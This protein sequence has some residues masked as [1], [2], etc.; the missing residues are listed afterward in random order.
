MQL[1]STNSLALCVVFI[2]LIACATGQAVHGYLHILHSSTRSRTTATVYESA[3][4]L[5]LMLMASFALGYAGETPGT[6]I[7]FLY[8]GSPLQPALWVNVAVAIVA[9][10][11]ALAGFEDEDLPANMDVSWIPAADALIAL[12]CIPP[13][14]NVLGDSWPLV[15]YIDAAYF[16]FRTVYALFADKQMRHKLV[17]PLSI[18]E[19]MKLLP[20]GLLYA[21]KHGRTLVANDAM[22][23]CLSALGLSTDFGRVDDL[24]ALLNERAAGDHAV[25][26]AETVEWERGNWVLLRIGPHEVRLFS[27]EGLGFEQ[28]LNYP[29]AK[30]LDEESAIQGESRRLLGAEAR[31]RVIAYDMTSEVEIMQEIDRT[32]AELADSQRELQE[33][34]LT[35]QEA[36]ENEAMLRMRGRVHDVIGQRLSMLHRALEDKDLSD[37]KLDQLKPLLNGILDDL[38]DGVRVEPADELSATVA[39]FALTGVD[40]RIDGAL[41]DDEQTAKLFV[42]CIR[43]GTTNAVK[44]AHATLVNVK[45]S[46]NSLSITND[47]ATPDSDIVEGTG[48]ANMRRAVEAAGGTLSISPSPFTLDIAIRPA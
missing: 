30:S 10:Y 33:S 2:A 9:G 19:A 15:L 17:S 8:L 31:M 18:A 22:R 40:V 37:E 29:S 3:L 24:W 42:D 32:N 44:H 48:L 26:V 4:L 25:P 36:A 41:P 14:A 16:L 34:M 45:C 28:D 43:E 35:V 38:S 27:F 13:V 12:I 47:G 23:H 21:D 1:A 7:H 11:T 5:H 20:E 39:A 6:Q 46:S